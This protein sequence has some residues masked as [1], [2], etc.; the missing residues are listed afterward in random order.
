MRL[1]IAIIALVSV[2]ACGAVPWNKQQYAGINSV[3]FEWCKIDGSYL[4]C[5]VRIIDGKEQGAIDFKFQMPDGT[6]LNFAAD[7]VKAFEG[8]RL[9]AE[10]EKA[11]AEQL[12]E[13]SPGL[14]DA[15][16]NAI[17]GV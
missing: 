16:L 4:P 7:N 9:R 10:V 11:I 14:V 6:I 2:S 8:Q 15:I 13:V 3:K 5:H 12:G 17:G 1:I